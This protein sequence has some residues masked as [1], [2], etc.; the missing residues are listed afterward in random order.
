M[1]TAKFSF[2]RDTFIDPKVLKKTKLFPEVLE[3]RVGENTTLLIRTHFRVDVLFCA[4]LVLFGRR[5]KRIFADSYAVPTHKHAR[6]HAHHISN[7]IRP[8]LLC[9]AQKLFSRRFRAK[10]RSDY[11]VK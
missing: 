10:N 4:R 6:T 5:T 2:A 1:L 8:Q 11:A 7:R 9:N 3:E